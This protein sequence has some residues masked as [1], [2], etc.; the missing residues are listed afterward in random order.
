MMSEVMWL[1]KLV[2]TPNILGDGA[3][4][5]FDGE[6]CGRSGFGFGFAVSFPVAARRRPRRRTTYPATGHLER[7]EEKTVFGAVA[8]PL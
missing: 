2:A 3:E 8:T 5:C 1:Q 7:T 6:K 4:G